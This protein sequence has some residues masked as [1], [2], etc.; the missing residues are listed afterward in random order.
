MVDG[1]SMGTQW[2]RR[3]ARAWA[4]WRRSLMM[5]EHGLSREMKARVSYGGDE[6]GYLDL[7]VIVV[8][9]LLESGF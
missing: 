7:K 5:A 9:E 6:F 8:V 1:L 2:D 3:A 4:R